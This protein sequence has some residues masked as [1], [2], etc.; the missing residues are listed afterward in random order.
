MTTGTSHEIDIQLTLD[1]HHIDIKLI[2]ESRS[3]DRVRQ[4]QA[5]LQCASSHYCHAS[6]AP[7]VRNDLRDDDND[8]LHTPSGSGESPPSRVMPWVRPCGELTSNWR[9]I[10]IKLSL[11]WCHI[12]VDAKMTSNFHQ[13]DVGLTSK[14]NIKMT[15]D[16]RW[17]AIKL[18]LDWRQIFVV[19]VNCL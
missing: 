3:K 6:K 10:Y 5:I 13:I 11:D 9:R 19:T 14:G 4:P 7:T 15:S 16:C 17:I 12:D 18:T 8:Q 2:F 1:W